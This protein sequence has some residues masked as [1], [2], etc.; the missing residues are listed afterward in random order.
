MVNLTSLTLTALTSFKNL[1]VLES[2]G[3]YK[4]GALSFILQTGW[5]SALKH[6]LRSNQHLT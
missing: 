4:V 5:L 3:S 6:Q 1:V 2:F